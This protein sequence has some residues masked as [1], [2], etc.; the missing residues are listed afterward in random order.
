[1]SAR[2]DPELARWLAGDPARQL[3]AIVSA[4]GRLDELLDGLPEGV[5]VQHLYRLIG[6]ISVTAPA[7]TLRRMADLTVVKS[8]EPVRRVSHCEGTTA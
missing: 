6:S 7:G 8:I 4:Q 5:E 3:E 2:I 1:M